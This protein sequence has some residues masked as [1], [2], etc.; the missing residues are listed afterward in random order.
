V[1]RFVDTLLSYVRLTLTVN[2][3]GPLDSHLSLGYLGRSIRTV[4][5]KADNLLHVAA[6]T[7]K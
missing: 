5:V 2:T 7:A 1:F 6:V 4:A 3:L